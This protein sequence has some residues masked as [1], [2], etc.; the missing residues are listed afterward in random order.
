MAAE[1]I[2]ATAIYLAVNR[3]TG[4]AGLVAETIMGCSAVVGVMT[5]MAARR[6]M[7]QADGAASGSPATNCG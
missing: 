2:V 6:I 3:T 4:G 1:A 7:V 5:T